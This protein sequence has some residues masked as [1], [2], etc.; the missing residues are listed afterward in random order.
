M[1]VE[2]HESAPPVVRNPREETAL[3]RLQEVL[4]G[5]AGEL[6]LGTPDGKSVLIPASL[7]RGLRVAADMLA[8]EKAVAL[9]PAHDISAAQAAAFLRV[10]Q[11]H[12]DKLLDEGELPFRHI[13]E[14]R[15]IKV[16]D[17]Y[18]YDERRHR[19]SRQL[20]REMTRIA[21]ESPGGYD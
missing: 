14:D 9:E 2:Q 20:L 18:A 12:L 17:L 19:L 5:A 4:D 13:G 6:Y 3:A 7:R 8:R 1:A 10:S 15:R 16:D 11:E 21:E